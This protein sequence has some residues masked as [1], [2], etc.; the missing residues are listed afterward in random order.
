M[1]LREQLAFL[2]FCSLTYELWVI[3]VLTL[4]WKWNHVTCKKHWGWGLAF[5][6]YSIHFHYYD[7]PEVQ[8]NQNTSK[9][10]LWSKLSLW[11]ELLKGLVCG[12]V[13]RVLTTYK[14]VI[15]TPANNLSTLKPEAQRSKV[16]G[17]PQLLA[18][19]DGEGSWPAPAQRDGEGSWH[20]SARA[21]PMFSPFICSLGCT[22]WQQLTNVYA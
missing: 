8:L 17:H 18:N 16:Q 1:T 2:R 20:T 3:T 14:S 9:S 21:K 11:G 4:F 19:L 5:S 10:F 13:G 22:K 12:T 15:G 7:L 6:N